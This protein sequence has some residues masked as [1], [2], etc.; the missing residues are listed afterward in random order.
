MRFLPYLT[1]F[2]AFWVGFPLILYWL[3]VWSNAQ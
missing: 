2:L 1:A 3:N